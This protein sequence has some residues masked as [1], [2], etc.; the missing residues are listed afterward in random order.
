MQSLSHK[1]LISRAAAKAGLTQADLDRALRAIAEVTAEA[2]C[3]GWAVPLPQIGKITPTGRKART[4]RNPRTGEVMEIAA[5]VVPVL[6]V[7]KG[8]KDLLNN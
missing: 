1:E 3:L 4:G 6:K 2:L 8:L 5:K 7:A